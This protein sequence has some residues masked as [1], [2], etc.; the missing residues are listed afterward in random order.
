MTEVFLTLSLVNE[1]FAGGLNEDGQEMLDGKWLELRSNGVSGNGIVDD[2]QLSFTPV[3]GN[4]A[5]GGVSVGDIP[6]GCAR[7]IQFRVNIPQ[8]IATAHSVYP[9]FLVAN[10]PYLTNGFGINFGY[11]FG[12]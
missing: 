6:S 11:N 7:Y 4:P 3:G 2:A 12:G 5:T 9:K 10:R 8:S 1:S